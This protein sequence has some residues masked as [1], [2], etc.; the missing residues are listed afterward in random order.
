MKRLLA[1][2]ALPLSLVFS[3]L[4]A[5]AA[6]EPPGDPATNPPC[7]DFLSGAGIYTTTNGQVTLLF[8][9]NMEA[10]T[11]TWV[12]YTLY[13]LDANQNQFSPPIVVA[14]SGSGTGPVETYTIPIPV[15]NP[16]ACTSSVWVYATTT[17]GPHEFD[18]AP[19]TGNFQVTYTDPVT[20]GCP[21]SQNFG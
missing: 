21:T 5:G 13:V 11:C 20:G 3:G 12:T 7:A 9:Y 15:S 17:A 19:T 18:R 1:L 10:N 8:H 14:R 4:T 6:T 16:Q 2:V